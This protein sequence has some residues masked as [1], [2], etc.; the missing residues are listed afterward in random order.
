MLS[1]VTIDMLTVPFPLY[2]TLKLIFYEH[3]LI[4]FQN[5]SPIMT[6]LRSVA[7]VIHLPLRGAL[8]L[9]NNHAY[10]QFHSGGNGDGAVVLFL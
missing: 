3:D 5:N 8:N 4:K 10:N 6:G 9:A 2:Y 7:A 1:Y